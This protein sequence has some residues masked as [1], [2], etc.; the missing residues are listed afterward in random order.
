MNKKELFEI[1]WLVLLC[2]SLPVVLISCVFVSPLVGAVS[3]L[4]GFVALSGLLHISQF[5]D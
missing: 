2:V 3:L 1:I 5:N 4:H